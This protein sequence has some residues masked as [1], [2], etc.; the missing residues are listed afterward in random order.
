MSSTN[1]TA[2]F[3]YELAN[4]ATQDK[5]PKEAFITTLEAALMS[6]APF[7]RFILYFVAY[8][9][10]DAKD[11]NLITRRSADKDYAD[12]YLNGK[13]DFGT[14]FA[15]IGRFVVSMI[16]TSFDEMIKDVYEE[17]ADAL[18][19]APKTLLYFLSVATDRYLEGEGD[20]TIAICNTAGNG[21][22]LYKFTG[23]EQKAKEKLFA[24]VVE[25]REKDTEGWTHGTESVD[26]I[27]NR[28]DEFYAYGSYYDYHI[29]Y[30]LERTDL[31]EEVEI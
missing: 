8:E 1:F 6:A 15:D 14:T 18:P 12:L 30:T 25:D 5:R 10:Q 24:Y 23:T 11:K 28:P 21:V 4:T 27:E 7:L 31:I 3:V 22:K 16:P 17:L 2:R 19:S 29:D 13:T 9:H 26:E 20:W